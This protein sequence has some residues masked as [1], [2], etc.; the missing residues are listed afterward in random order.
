MEALFQLIS[1]TIELHHRTLKEL[2]FTETSFDLNSN[3]EKDFFT[4]LSFP[5]FEKIVLNN[6]KFVCYDSF[7]RFFANLT[8]TE[9]TIKHFEITRLNSAVSAK[10]FKEF[11]TS[12]QES[13]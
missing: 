9:N 6:C 2:C 4:S 8:D 7:E 3:S 10:G 5:N 11:L 13:L 12:Q 1:D